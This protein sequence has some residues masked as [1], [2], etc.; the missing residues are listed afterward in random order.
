M[1]VIM[2]KDKRGALI[3]LIVCI[4]MLDRIKRDDK[5]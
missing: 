1:I 4:N 5:I 3:N 2:I